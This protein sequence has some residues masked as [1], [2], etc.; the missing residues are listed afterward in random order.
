M[1]I[2]K[3]HVGDIIIKDISANSTIS[4][5]DS[6]SSLT[7]NKDENILICEHATMNQEKRYYLNLAF[8]IPDN[9]KI[10]SVFYKGDYFYFN[11]DNFSSMAFT[12]FL[13][14]ASFTKYS[15]CNICCT[16]VTNEMVCSVCGNHICSV[17]YQKINRCPYCKSKS[18]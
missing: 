10:V 16:N 1:N 9:P 7:D 6:I 3:P 15:K 14:K 2:I 13:D 18:I 17:C 8:T 4:I 12:K 11:N 5:F